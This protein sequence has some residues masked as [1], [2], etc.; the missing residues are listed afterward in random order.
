MRRHDPCV[1]C[2]SAGLNGSF[3]LP[4]GRICGLCRRRL[5][6]H[7]EPC[8]GCGNVK[9]LAY[10]KSDGSIV[11]A[12]C[13][14]A[15]SIF[16]CEICGRE[17]HPYGVRRCARCVIHDRLTT[18]LTDPSTGC[19]HLRLRPV[20]DALAGSDRPQTGIYWLRRPPGDGP[21]L[22]GMMAR[23]EIPVSHEVFAT[24]P[25]NRSHT[26]LRSLLVGVGVLDAFDPR[27]EQTSRWIT[28]TIERVEGR[29]HA[30]L[31]RR[32]A[33]WHVL[34][35][36]G[37]AADQ[38]TLTKGQSEAARERITAAIQFLTWAAQ[39]NTE[40][41]NITQ[42]HLD[43]YL[44]R[45]P[46]RATSLNGFISW[47]HTSRVNAKLT[48]PQRKQTL[49]AVTLSDQDRWRNIE[50]LLHDDTIRRYVRIAGLFMLLFAQ[51]LT[52]ICHLR[53]DQIDLAA[54]RVTVTFDSMPIEMPSPLDD[55]IREQTRA[56]GNASY[57]GRNNGWLLPGGIPGRPLTTENIRNQLVDLG[58]QPHTSRHAAMFQLAAEI[59]APILA[60]LVGIHINTATSWASLAARTWT[61][62]IAERA[63]P[64][65]NN[66]RTK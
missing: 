32:Y 60:E 46:G 27:A 44:A 23:G 51:P 63:R 22:L 59:P 56:R 3:V 14:G 6:Y 21:R 19:I 7:P 38:R 13:A 62:Y 31:L 43:A 61:S 15:D 18:L 66:A 39:H 50:T 26:Y 20:F 8:P 49:P 53:T 52:K 54:D 55:L 2:H 42:S 37:A 25:T 58:I 16:A 12:R 11:C 48:V 64:D 57:A 30:D 4:H 29:A 45:Y 28:D 33:R 10:R 9:P 5:A 65:G 1:V 35:R 41:G 36:L 34:R 17:D 40:A 47:L 24:L